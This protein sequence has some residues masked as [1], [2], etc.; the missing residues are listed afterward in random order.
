MSEPILD[1][2]DTDTLELAPYGVDEQGHAFP[3][4]LTQQ[5]ILDWCDRVRAGQHPRKGIP[6]L[7]VQHGVNSG[8]TRGMLAPVLEYALQ[9]PGLNLLIGRKEF[10]NLRKSAMRTF[11]EIV[12]EPLITRRSEQEHWVELEA[13]E[14]VSRVNFSELANWSGKGSQEFAVILV[15]E[16]HELASENTYRVLKQR[17]RQGL[18]P[19]FLL[20]EGNPPPP[21]HWLS[22]L[23][24]PLHAS[25]DSDFEVWELS[26]E[27]NWQHM[28]PAY[29][30]MLQAMP[31]SWKQRYLLG[32]S[33]F[34]PSGT[35]VYP[36]FH[37]SVHS[38]ATHLIPDRPLLRAWD[39]G[40]RRA[41]CLWS[42]K[43][44]A[45]QLLLHREWMPIETPET[46][47]IM[48][49]IERTNEWYGPRSAVD[50]GDPAA[51]NRDPEGVTTLN[52]LLRHDIRLISRQSTYAERIP[53]I[54][55]RLSLM[56][57]GE[58]AII[59]D[60]IGCPILTQA[61]LGG[62][63]FPAIDPDRK[64]TQKMEVPDHDQW[65]S[66]LSNA[67]EYLCLNLFQSMLSPQQE[68][69][70]AMRLLAPQRRMRATGVVSF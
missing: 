2:P 47:F 58:P 21:G 68:E 26:S 18:R 55:Q 4:H 13:S 19:S 70:K 29:R 51:R 59:V 6:V 37:E 52:R 16:A 39:F 42:Q 63:H 46:E 44:D 60:P 38:R 3:P 53:L 9:S 10:I 34:L 1:D 66:H 61:L 33:G 56:I 57:H 11:F 41:A 25:Y 20:L 30:E 40:Y 14:G 15:V 17:C 28:S 24:D 31:S 64:F 22:H 23:S 7:Y 48:G 5:R 36:A 50:Y 43:T 62:Y 27:E 54:N 8:G 67:F 65:F 49:V 69:R 12:P 32:K 45:G 35:P